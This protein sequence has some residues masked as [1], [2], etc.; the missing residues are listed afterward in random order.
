M[1]FIISISRPGKSLHLY[2]G[3]GKSWKA[4]CFLGIK[5]QKDK[6]LRKILNES[7]S[8]QIDTSR[9]FIHYNGRKCVK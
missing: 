6:K 8:V 5:K 9:Y 1:K 4:I 7:V 3:H 2:E